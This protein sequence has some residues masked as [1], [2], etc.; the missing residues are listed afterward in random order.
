[1]LRNLTR[2]FDRPAALQERVFSRL[3]EA[4]EISKFTQQQ[5]VEYEDSLKVYRDWK[6]TIVTAHDK[7]KAEGC[8]EERFKIASNLLSQGIDIPSIATATGLTVEQIRQIK[9]S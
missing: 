7:G 9:E 1:M 6:N 3:F 2:L 4:A 8:E 5:L